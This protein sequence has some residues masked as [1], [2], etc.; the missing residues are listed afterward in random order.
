MRYKVT[1]HI[2]AQKKKN[3]PARIKKNSPPFFD[4]KR[5]ALEHGIIAWQILNMTRK[6]A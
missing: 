2:I 6:K 5:N 1:K 3:I 4:F